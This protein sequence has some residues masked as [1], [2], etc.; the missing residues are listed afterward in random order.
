MATPGERVAD[1]L[2]FLLTLP[3]RAYRLLLS[4]LLPP[5]CR[6]HPSCSRYALAA[7]HAHGPW[8]GTFLMVR[9][10][11]RCQPFH[12]GGVDPVPPPEGRRAARLGLLPPSSTR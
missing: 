8:R 11:S 1:L 3:I 2:V 6:F 7:L 5:V 4:P 12:P 10:L 9:R